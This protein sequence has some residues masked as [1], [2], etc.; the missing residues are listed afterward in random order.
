MKLSL[1][2]RSI[3]YVGKKLPYNTQVI[4]EKQSLP[5]LLS[6]L[7]VADVVLDKDGFGRGLAK[8]QL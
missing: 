8:G 3:I 6:E 4:V 5:E 1:L 7:P 2:K